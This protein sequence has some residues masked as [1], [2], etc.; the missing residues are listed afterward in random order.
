MRED[1]EYVG[2]DAGTKRNSCCCWA[3]SWDRPC[4]SLQLLLTG[5]CSRGYSLDTWTSS[6]SFTPLLLLELSGNGNFSR[7]V[8]LTNQR[9]GVMLSTVAQMWVTLLFCFPK[10]NYVTPGWAGSGRGSLAGFQ[11]CPA[12]ELNFLFGFV[13]KCTFCFFSS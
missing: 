9:P 5:L 4:Y 8:Q 2:L 1:L 3:C 7:M 6:G 13:L 11:I 10:A 12:S